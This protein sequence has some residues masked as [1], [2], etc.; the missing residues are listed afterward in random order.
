MG[1]NFIARMFC[2]AVLL[3]VCQTLADA[4]PCS[5]P[6]WAMV[7]TPPPG[8][9]PAVT[10]LLTDGRVM[11]QNNNLLSEWYS[12][13]PD[14]A[15][16]YLN[17]T[18]RQLA[19]ITWTPLYFASA[20]LADGKVIVEGGE[21]D[22]GQLV[23]SNKGA[24]Y[25]PEM[26]TWTPIAPPAGWNTIGDAQS[27]V[28]SNGTFMMAQAAPFSEQ[29]KKQALLN[30]GNLSWTSTGTGKAD[31]NGEEGFT[32]LPNGQVL[33]V[34]TKPVSGHPDNSEVYTF[35]ANPNWASAG[36]TLVQLYGPCSGCSGEIGP[37]VLLQNGKV[38]ATGA[39]T[40]DIHS[41]HTAVYDPKIV[42][43]WSIGPDLPSV[44][45][46]NA[47]MSDTPAALLTDG[48]VL[49]AASP[50]GTGFRT[51]VFLEWAPGA[52]TFTVDPLPS[53]GAYAG[54]SLL[55]LPTGQVMYTASNTPTPDVFAPSG[56]PC[57][58]CAPTI[59]SVPPMLTHG[60]KN[61]L[62]QGTQFNGL[63][64]DSMYGDDLQNATNYP[65][66]RITNRTTGRVFY[67]KTHD[68]STMAVATGNTIVS[69]SFD[70]PTSID[71]GLSNLV[72]IANGIASAPMTVSVF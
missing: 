72:V 57:Q 22:N 2:A 28:L 14:S 41:G 63:S 48:N 10:L 49:L 9:S 23:R 35:N 32:L 44:G 42:Q 16:S 47:D 56:T 53:D 59:T 25:D 51:A 24:L 65:L 26:D 12:L 1:K 20:V 13:T 31:N 71:I 45:G 11:I 17:G 43:R 15:G 58:S 62:I 61:Y 27:I 30:E 36:S 67:C 21:Y 55:M 6:C 66:V 46:R 18:W 54:G 3:A 29:T 8:V 19:S 39:S 37:A 7:N 70:V 52:T 4:Q 50:L 69:T 33:T 60:T 64:Q 38:F 40:D 5:P 68:H 34:D